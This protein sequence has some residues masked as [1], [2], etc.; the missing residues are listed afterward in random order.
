MYPT[1]LSH[2]L[3]SKRFLE[4]PYNFFLSV[5]CIANYFIEFSGGITFEEFVLNLF[6]ALHPPTYIHSNMVA[7]I[8]RCLTGHL[9]KTKPE[10]F[11]GVCGCPDAE[12]VPE[13][14]ARIQNYAYHAALCHDFGKICILRVISTYG[15]KILDNEFELIK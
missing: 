2:F 15:R 7:K 3:F 9:L 5:Q 4:V 1:R 10:L 13:Y 12:H 6:A 14:E 8:S 11:T